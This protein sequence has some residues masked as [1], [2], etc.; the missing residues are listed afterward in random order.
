[1]LS[2][3][4]LYVINVRYFYIISYFDILGKHKEIKISHNTDMIL[5]L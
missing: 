1:M 3:I 2:V 4:M 5:L